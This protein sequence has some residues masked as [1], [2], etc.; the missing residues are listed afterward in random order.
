[1]FICRWTSRTS[2]GR[3]SPSPSS[4]QQDHFLKAPGAPDVVFPYIRCYLTK[5]QRQDAHEIVVAAIENK[6]VFDPPW[7]GEDQE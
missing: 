6:S 5:Q 1:M 2:T 3:P 4:K 7:I